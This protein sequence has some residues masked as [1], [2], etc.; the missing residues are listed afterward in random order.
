MANCDVYPDRFFQP[1]QVWPG[2]YDNS[3]DPDW[4]PRPESTGV[5]ISKETPIV[6]LG[7]CFSRQIKEILLEDG[8][9]L[10]AE[11][12]DHK[13][14][15]HASAAWERV[16]NTFSMRQ[17]F[18]YTFEDWEPSLRWW[19]GPNTGI[20]QDPYRRI[21]LYQTRE[22][23]EADF[24][25]HR[26][27]SRRVLEKAGILI[28]TLETTEIWEDRL[29]GA[30]ISLPAGPYVSEGGDMSRYRF[31]VSRYEENMRNMEYIFEI[32]ARYN[33]CCQIILMV[34]PVHLWATFREDADVIS[35]GA[36]AKATLRAV[37]DEC[38]ARHEKVFYFPALEIATT[39]RMIYGEPVFAPGREN[40]HPGMENVRNIMKQFYHFYDA[41]K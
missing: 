40:F 8:Y 29:D 34:S 17:I 12:Q 5:T 1:W 27:C 15:K 41:K 32:M 22:E 2:S 35:A 9:N 6:S 28:L 30:V 21:I 31:R 10:I 11:E 23:A 19:Q 14:A 37:A 18:G 36:N 39:Y 25:N 13:A 33:P 24:A 38:A 20:I 4:Y 26:L 3:G 7:S 16:Y